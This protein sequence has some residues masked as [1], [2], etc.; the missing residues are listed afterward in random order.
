MRALI[1]GICIF[2]LLFVQILSSA[3]QSTVAVYNDINNDP[4]AFANIVFTPF[5]NN[6]IISGYVTDI[7]GKVDIVVEESC[8]I[9][10]SYVGF[11]DYTDT[12]H[13]GENKNIYLSSISYNMDEVV[14]TG[15]YSESRQ[16]KSIYKVQ[17]IN[18][19]EIQ[20]RGAVNL[21]EMLS[22]ELNIRTSQD[23]ALGSS[24]KMQGL[25]GEHVKFLID[26]VPVIGR[27]N[28][29]ID[30]DQLNLQ[31]IDHIEII[32]GPMSVAYGSNALA[33]VI[34]II[35]K[36]PDRLL[37]SSNLDGYYESVGVYN[38]NMAVTGRAKRNSFGFTGGRNFFDGFQ[39]PGT[40]WA[41]RW[42]PREQWNFSGDYKYNWDNTQI[43]LGATYFNQELRDNGILMPP[44]Y[45]RRIDKYYFTQRLVIKSNVKYE[46]NSISR[47]N[48]IASYSRYHKIRNVYLN[49]LTILDKTLVPGEQDTT[50]FSDIL[51]RADYSYG[52][53]STKLKFQAG[54]DLNSE[55]GSG[56]RIK[57]NEQIIGDY[58]LFASFNYT[59]VKVLNIQ[60]GLRFI[61]N[62]KFKAPVVYSINVKY[63]ISEFVSMRASVASGFRAPSLKELYLNFVD[64]NHDI[65]GNENLQAETSVS[66]NLL[67]QYNSSQNRGYVWGIE[68]NLFN[69]N[70]K[71]N[72]QLIPQGITSIYYTY[73]NVNRYLTRGMEINFN[74]K[75][76]P[77]LTVK[78]GF[79]YTGQKIDYEGLSES[80][81]EYY[82]GFNTV[83]SYNVQKWNTTF[84]LY[85]KYNGKYPQLY[86]IGLEETPEILYM[87]PYNTLDVTIGK[88]F[89][90][91]R[92]NLQIGAKNLFNNTNVNVT[93]ASQGGVHTGGSGS[94]S[95]NWGRTFFA[96]LQITI[97]K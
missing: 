13:A 24:L 41:Q 88:W 92:I 63:D 70:I 12:I 59:P 60:P 36:S 61:Y 89:W 43:N 48:A 91:R 39:A 53:E 28:G 57:D 86:F 71:D 51:L 79:T 72:I 85:Y 49:D 19:K 65:Q 14:V 8:L 22:T 58:A 77:W 4:V 37:Y 69:N 21:K 50:L 10:L 97:N 75:V 18:S 83:A 38:L 62:T 15:Q 95:V 46:L 7:N 67:L 45:E 27:E 33:G 68:M 35:T 80:N 56:K 9:K 94:Q 16:D 30:L 40:N 84:S 2:L 32:N 34:N 81:F 23:N 87:E 66:T 73:V 82:T 42:K 90:K 3:Q 44:Y 6:T 78:F 20:H 93:G 26:G 17:V 54:V 5:N 29:N 1:K 25:G 64:V 74:N 11:Q 76:Y 96:R 52:N 55:K 31:N 47:I